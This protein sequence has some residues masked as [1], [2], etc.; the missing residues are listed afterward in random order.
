M[1]QG[2]VVVAN[3]REGPRLDGRVRHPDEAQSVWLRDIEYFYVEGQFYRDFP[4]G[5]MAV[6]PPYGAVLRDLPVDA[7]SVWVN[8]I[9]YAYIQGIYLRR[10]QNGYRVVRSPLEGT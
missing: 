6:E 9:E 8:D 4:N 3:E 7:Q 2:P 1:D 5:L 10:I